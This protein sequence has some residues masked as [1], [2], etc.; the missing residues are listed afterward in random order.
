M[1]IILALGRAEVG[2]WQQI[3][4]QPDISSEFRLT[5]AT[6]CETVLKEKRK[7]FTLLQL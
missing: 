5:W 7:K 2:G 3:G 4:G 1:P 6:K